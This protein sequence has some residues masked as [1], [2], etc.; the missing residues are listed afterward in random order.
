MPEIT[1]PAQGCKQTFR[2]DLDAAVL[3]QLIEIHATTNHPK[4]AT[5]AP[6]QPPAHKM[7]RVRRPSIST[8]GTSEDWAY[9]LTRW[10]EYKVATRLTG[11]D[12]L[13]QLLECAD[14]SLRKDIKE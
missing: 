7:E 12:V 11:D 13:I 10:A 14:E 6:A 5:P 9:F 8:S 3:R 2:D 1:C 4:P